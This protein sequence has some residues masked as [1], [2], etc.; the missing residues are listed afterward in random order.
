M[1][2]ALGVAV[3]ALLPWQVRADE[4][5]DVERVLSRVAAAVERYYARAQ[6]VM[7][8]ETVTQQTLTLGMQSDGTPMRRLLYD[9]RV[10]WNAISGGDSRA[11]VQRELLRVNNREP[12][13]K[14]KPKCL[15]PSVVAPDSLAML[16]P[17]N[18]S[19]YTFSAAGSA[20][21]SGRQAFMIDY[22]PVRAGAV[23]VKPHDDVEECWS[24]DMP[25]RTRGRVWVDAETGDVLRFDEHLS[26]YTE[27]VISSKYN[28]RQTVVFERLDSS[29]TYRP[30][31][32]TNP[33]ETL[34]LPSSSEL[35]QLVRNAGTPGLRST[36]K[37][38]DY[39]R[40]ETDGR[41]V[42]DRF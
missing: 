29:T 3:C 33:N 42:T 39:R 40:F 41:I 25:G 24:I 19:D 9:L 38:S 23:S 22:K 14:D 21:V 16:L 26:G 30:V 37:F 31:A 35:L 2:A 20:R 28:G 17:E 18:R 32:F 27:A 13:P 11:T 34:M 15:D 36:H 10:A 1:L 5:F 4:P 12:R 8:L 6:S 7:C